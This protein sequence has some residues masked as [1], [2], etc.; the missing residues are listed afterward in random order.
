MDHISPRS[1]FL[2]AFDSATQ[3]VILKYLSGYR[4]DIQHLKDFLKHMGYSDTF[5]PWMEELLSQLQWPSNS[6]YDKVVS[7]HLNP[8]V[9]FEITPDTFM[10]SPQ[11]DIYQ[12]LVLTSPLPFTYTDQDLN[13]PAG[14]MISGMSFYADGMN[15]AVL[16]PTVSTHKRKL[17]IGIKGLPVKELFYHRE[18]FTTF[19]N[20][21]EN[22]M[23]EFLKFSRVALSHEAEATKRR[24][25]NTLEQCVNRFVFNLSNGYT[26]EHGSKHVIG[27]ME[28]V[29]HSHDVSQLRLPFKLIRALK[30]GEINLGKQSF[31]YLL[32]R[33]LA[34]QQ[35]LAID[36]SSPDSDPDHQE[37]EWKE[38]LVKADSVNPRQ[39]SL[40]QVNSRVE[41]TRPKDIDRT[42]LIEW[43]GMGFNTLYMMGIY[44]ESEFS[45]AYNWFWGQL[46]PL[47]GKEV[48]TEEDLSHLEFGHKDLDWLKRYMF[49]N[50]KM[51]RKMTLDEHE[52]HDYNRLGQS[53]NR[54]FFGNGQYLKPLLYEGKKQRR[55]SAFAIKAY[56]VNPEIGGEQELR[57]L[58]REASDL[59]IR[60]ILDFVPNHMAMD[61]DYLPLHPEYFIHETLPHHFYIDSGVFSSFDPENWHRHANGR[62]RY[63]LWHARSFDNNPDDT[64][65]YFLMQELDSTGKQISVIKFY[66]GN[67]DWKDT[68][69]LDITS[70][71]FREFMRN[72]YL[73]ALALT[74]GGGVRHDFVHV[75]LK[76][77]VR[78]VWHANEEWPLYLR[79]YKGVRGD[80]KSPYEWFQL[81]EEFKQIYFSGESS[82]ADGYESGRELLSHLVESFKYFLQHYKN[83][84]YIS[85]APA[86]HFEGLKEAIYQMFYPSFSESQFKEVYDSVMNLQFFE[87]LERVILEGKKEYPESINI[88][89]AYTEQPY[90]MSLGFDSIYGSTLQKDLVS[91]RIAGESFSTAVEWFFGSLRNLSQEWP[92]HQW[93]LYLQNFDEEPV[94][95]HLNVSEVKAASALL[96]GLPGLKFFEWGMIEGSKTRLSADY[97]YPV[98]DP[99]LQPE[100]KDFFRQLVPLLNL[101][102]I[103]QGRLTLGAFKSRSGQTVPVYHRNYGSDQVSILVNTSFQEQI[104]THEDLFE[105]S[106]RLT[107]ENILLSTEKNARVEDGCLVIPP[108]GVVWLNN[109]APNGLVEVHPITRRAA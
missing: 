96:Y 8:Y 17:S 84:S 5:R 13:Q 102:T 12:W 28:F 98:F 70:P 40:I 103:Q 43:K 32:L 63:R 90:L 30:R 67:F 53:F 4:G 107:Q 80:P 106:R 94:I 93:V 23:Q 29:S 86:F 92:I 108:C 52:M 51:F 46:D 50:W 45:K 91:S 72:N 57:R 26:I 104:I 76:D 100:L 83:L 75:T 27:L 44:E 35:H 99:S 73:T 64:K 88:A 42:K 85:L 21:S 24:F 69:Q 95:N 62:V 10:F 54:L 25:L 9:L 109:H 89:E 58:V 39:V 41:G 71:Y 55:A 78:R 77:H 59:G 19:V 14:G 74:E 82:R 33:D 97:V 101:E 22:L 68:V 38:K 16:A 66:H 87:F 61:N 7:L 3:G 1:E 60:V 56:K 65:S 49:L 81:L 6:E 36:I 37:T 47:T 11:I 31:F 105:Q 34:E 15:Y 2:N 79:K 18:N 20:Y 48:L